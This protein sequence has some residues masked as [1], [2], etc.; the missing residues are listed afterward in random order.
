MR[1]GLQNIARHL[2]GVDIG[3][4]GHRKQNSGVRVKRGVS[5]LDCTPNAH[6]PHIV[7]G[8]GHALFGNFYQAPSQFFGLM[9][10]GHAPHRIFVV[11]LPQNPARGLEAHRG[12][13]L[14]HIF[15]RH[16]VG[17]H[18]HGVGQH[19]ILFVVAAHH[20]HLAHAP[21]CQDSGFDDPI[22]QG[23]QLHHV[24]GIG[25][26][27]HKEDFAHHAALRSQNGRDV[28]RQAAFEGHQLF[29]H[30]LACFVNICTPIEFNPN[31]RRPRQ[32][33]R[34][35]PPHMR[36]PV[37]GGFDRKSNQTLHLLGGH[38]LGIGHHGHGGRGEVGKHID[39]QMTDSIYAA[40]QQHR[41]PEKNE[42]LIL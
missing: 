1:K 38:V 30:N 37:H 22:G 42:K 24:G 17:V 18:Q 39:I 31:E 4:F 15:Q 21:R 10:A 23:A 33:R 41:H 29:A 16:P 12:G 7:Q 3:L 34:A 8:Y 20:R 19:L 25:F 2:Q 36:G 27:R 5:H 9:R 6:L 26:E 13:G 11:V 28:L 14:G 40:R 32:R 35:H